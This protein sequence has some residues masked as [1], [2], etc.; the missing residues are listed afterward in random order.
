MMLRRQS[1]TKAEPPLQRLPSQD[2]YKA[3]VLPARRGRRLHS[4]RIS[5]T[6]DDG[7]GLGRANG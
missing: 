3:R 7:D 1:A 6:K 4:G 5:H 2:K